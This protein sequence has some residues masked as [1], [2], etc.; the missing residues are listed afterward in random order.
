MTLALIPAE[1][2]AELLLR[3]SRFIDVRAPVEFAKGSIPGA[4]NL[5]LLTTEERERVGICYKQHGQQAAIALGHAL[6]NGLVKEARVARWCEFL[7]RHPDTHLFCWR[8]GLRSR[9]AAQWMAEAGCPIRVVQGGYKEL[10]HRLLQ[11]IAAAS[12]TEPMVIVGGRTGSA[13]TDLITRLEGGIDLEAA[14]RHRGSSFGR[15]AVDPP[16]QI[17]FENDVALALLRRRMTDPGGTIFL[18]DEGRLIGAATLPIDLHAAMKRSPLAVVEMPLE[19]RVGQ[20]LHQYICVNLDDYLAQDAA[21]GFDNFAT[22][23]T[24]SLAR[25]QRRL[26]PER[27]ALA[28]VLLH[29]ALIAHRERN[30]IDAHRAWIELLLREYYDPMYDYQLG[31][32]AQRIAFRGSW[33]EVF[34]WCDQIS[35]TRPASIA[36]SATPTRAA[37]G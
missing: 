23:L 8:G 32:S 28:S 30:E 17:N 7:R 11:E 26:G 2:F 27:F 21:G 13:K 4:V 14:A 15:R 33:Q 9:T 29:E 24:Q 18:E 37:S 12:F 6:V 19:F 1:E 25:I 10:R 34:E 5:P 22:H 31:K 35:R 36:A 16:A 3:G 20:I